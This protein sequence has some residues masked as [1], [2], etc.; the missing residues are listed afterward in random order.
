MVLEVLVPDLYCQ[1]F[2]YSYFSWSF[3]SSSLLRIFLPDLLILSHTVSSHVTIR[4][5]YNPT[6]PSTQ[7]FRNGSDNGLLP[8]KYCNIKMFEITGSF[9]TPNSLTEAEAVFS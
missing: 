3:V 8:L 5:S 6:K 2:T 4:Y 1:L 9:T 7:L